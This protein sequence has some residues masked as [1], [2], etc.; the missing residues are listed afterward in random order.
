M[1]CKTFFLIIHQSSTWNTHLTY[2]IDDSSVG[3]DS[4]VGLFKR[5]KGF[6]IRTFHSNINKSVDIWHVNEQAF[7][8]A[9]VDLKQQHTNL[10]VHHKIVCR[11]VTH[12]KVRWHGKKGL[13][14][15][16][17]SD[18]LIELWMMKI[19][20]EAKRLKILL[21]RQEFQPCKPFYLEWETSTIN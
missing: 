1:L 6:S 14:A 18:Y 2:I 8:S 9:A 20:F 10:H 17:F 7:F 12:L 4:N 16:I 3:D 19:S 21:V 15:F 11:L 5:K 13:S